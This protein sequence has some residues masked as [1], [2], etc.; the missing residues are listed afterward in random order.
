M[1]TY[2]LV[3]PHCRGPIRIRTSEGQH[4]CLRTAYLQ[5][6]N[7]ACGATFRAQFEITHQMSPSGMPNP[8]VQLPAAPTSIR[9]ESMRNNDETQLDLLEA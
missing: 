3:C 6:T 5:C 9:R 8:Q 7:E 4:I 2:K 1:S